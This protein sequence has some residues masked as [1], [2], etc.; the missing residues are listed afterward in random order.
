MSHIFLGTLHFR[1]CCWRQKGCQGS[2][3]TKAWFEKIWFPFG[4]NYYSL[5]SSERNPPHQ[6]CHLAH[7]RTQWTGSLSLSP[8][9]QGW[10]W[11]YIHAH[12]IHPRLSTQHLGMSRTGLNLRI[13]TYI[14]MKC[15]FALSL[16]SVCE[17]C[18][19]CSM[20]II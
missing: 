14:S 4:R 10:L 6:A 11:T 17:S 20:S 12:Y 5:N 9:F 8:L 18:L 3:T 13:L 19:L 7:L 16:L 2:L 15:T 1:Q